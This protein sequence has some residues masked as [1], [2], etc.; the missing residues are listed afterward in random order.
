MAQFFRHH[1][2][3]EATWEVDYNKEEK[4]HRQREEVA[5]LGTLASGAF[6]LYENYK[7]KKDPEHERRHRIEEEIA[8]VAAVGGA[9]YALHEHHEKKEAI[10]E[11][12]RYYYNY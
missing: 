7:A 5:E 4:R 9:G 1:E 3:S 6:A 8:A 2:E 11:G 12:K 10:Q